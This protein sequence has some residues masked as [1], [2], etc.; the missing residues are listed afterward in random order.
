MTSGPT[1]GAVPKAGGAPGVVGVAGFW[2]KLV[3]D[4][5]APSM[6]RVLW[7]RN[8]LRDFDM[9]SSAADCSGRLE[10][11]C[12]GEIPSEIIWLRQIESIVW[13]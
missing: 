4:A 10:R 13:G 3:V 12:R 7:V 1:A 6:V 9:W 5:A 11:S 2:A 8:S